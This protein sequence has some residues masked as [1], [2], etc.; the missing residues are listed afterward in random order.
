MRQGNLGAD[1]EAHDRTAGKSSSRRVDRRP[2]IRNPDSRT[3]FSDRLS[4]P[5][6]DSI[7][8]TVHNFKYPGA[9]R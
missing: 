3:M 8:K 7:T 6:I 2:G 1:S 9:D 5:V 4:V